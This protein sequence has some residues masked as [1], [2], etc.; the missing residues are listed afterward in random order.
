M[1]SDGL[2]AADLDQQIASLRR[3]TEE[4]STSMLEACMDML[5]V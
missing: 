3:A 1:A 2:P 5:A 4:V